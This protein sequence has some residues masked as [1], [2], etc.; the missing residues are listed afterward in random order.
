M[1]GDVMLVARTIS[2]YPV[3]S[4]ITRVSFLLQPSLRMRKKENKPR[5][6]LK[7]AQSQS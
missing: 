1:M 4:P 2:I 7:L 6:S 5:Q 3:P